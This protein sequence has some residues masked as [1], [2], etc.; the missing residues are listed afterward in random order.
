[1]LK[2]AQKGVRQVID[3]DLSYRHRLVTR[4]PLGSL[5]VDQA[6]MRLLAKMLQ[7]SN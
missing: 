2:K 7:R 1:M 6:A 5:V 4:V 3:I